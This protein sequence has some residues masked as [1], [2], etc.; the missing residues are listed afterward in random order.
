MVLEGSLVKRLLTDDGGVVPWLIAR[1]SLEVLDLAHDALAVDDFA[2]DHVLLVEMW[3]R[4]SRDEEL[5]SICTFLAVSSGPQP[6]FHLLLTYQAP[7]SPC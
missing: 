7:R 3:C 2:E 1:L 4:N 6:S 5:T